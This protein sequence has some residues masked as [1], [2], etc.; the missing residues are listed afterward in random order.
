[1]PR[2]GCGASGP[3]P[4]GSGEDPEYTRPVEYKIAPS[5]LGADLARLGDQ[6]ASVENVA[7]LIHL[8]VMDG[9]FVPNLS[10]G[11]PVIAALRPHSRLPFDVHVMTS[12]PGAYLEELA[13]A[14]ADL[15]TV[16]LEAVPDPAPTIARA[17]SAG[18][19][20][21]IVISPATPWE[22]MEP[23]VEISDMVVIMSVNPGFGGQAFM[24]EVLG[25][26]EFARKWI[27]SHGLSTDIE[28][29]GGI[30]TATLPLARD[31]GAN[32]FVAGSAVFGEPDPAAA[33]I[34]LREVIEGEPIG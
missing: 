26:V 10:F 27:D 11:M 4:S 25:K 2:I 34:R 22:A 33:V 20:V 23:F 17:R 30:D 28:V 13:E 9:H 12:N 24:P 21:G 6:L 5:I 1:M 7:D 3:C 15:V 14:G 16:H 29:D 19:S 18:L 32:V 31:A 8:D